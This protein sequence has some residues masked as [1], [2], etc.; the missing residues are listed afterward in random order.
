MSGKDGFAFR[1]EQL[2][3]PNLAAIPVIIYSGYHNVH[4]AA[5]ELHVTASFQKPV[6]PVKFL[7]LV[8]TY[9]Y[10]G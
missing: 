10:R 8:K 7:Q 5:L 2:A 9:R 1:E 4:Y 3:D 6:D